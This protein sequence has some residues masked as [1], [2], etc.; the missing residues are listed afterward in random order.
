MSWLNGQR[1]L[2]IFV[3][4]AAAA[5]SDMNGPS[6]SDVHLAVSWMEWP[7]AVTADQPGS[8]RILGYRGLCGAFQLSV[9]QSGPSSVSVAAVEHFAGDPVLC[10]SVA[11][12]FDT[13]VPLPRLVSPVGPSAPFDVDAETVNPLGVLTRRSFG[14]VQ[15]SSNQPDATLHVGGQ[16]VVLADSLGCSW[17]RPALPPNA[18]SYVL[19]GNV[20]LGT[21]SWMTAF[22]GGSLV[23]VSSLHCG[24]H[25]LLQLVVLE[26]AIG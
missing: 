22:A 6:G 21:T 20:T 18:P 9:T 11:V 15:L 8:V 17:L 19:S 5:C 13:V 26:V 24:Q 12:L 16:A 3:L 2:Q 7:G 1:G 10:P 23:P 25:T 14:V 4:L